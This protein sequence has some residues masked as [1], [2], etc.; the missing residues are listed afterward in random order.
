MLEVK[1]L[2]FSYRSYDGKEGRRLFDNISFSLP[3]KGTLL[4]LG[5]PGSGKSTLSLILS[6]LAP[7]FFDGH[8]EGDILLDGRS[9]PQAPEL[10]GVLSLV[11]QDS[12]QFII[13][14]Q[15]ED[16]IVYPLESLGV[17]KTKMDEKLAYE[18]EQWGLERLRHAGT[19][20][21]SGGEKR[22]LVLSASLVTEPEIVIYDE[23]FDDLDI[24]WRRKLADVIRSRRSASLVFAS[25]Y[26]PFFDGLFD[27][28]FVLKDG[29]LRAGC[30]DDFTSDIQFTHPD[31][32]TE[33]SNEL[34]AEGIVYTHHRHIRGEA[35]DFTLHADNFRLRSGEIVTLTGANG[36]GKS[37]FSRLLCGL[38]TPDEGMFS[39]NGKSADGSLLRRSAGYMFQ[40]PDFQIFLPTVRDELSFSLDYLKLSRKDKDNRL[41]ELAEL[42][43]LKLDETASLMSFG[44]RK[45]LQAAIYYNLDRP[46]FILDELDSALNYKEAFR[47]VSLLASRGAGIIL[48]THDADFASSVRTRGYGIEE[49]VLYEK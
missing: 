42:F 29:Q 2:S 14:S 27:Q 37:T 21:L 49:G 35:G 43:S 26:L 1:E 16:E 5:E 40:N 30:A 12:S 46:F 47:L 8:L 17:D 28:I 38:D 9:L 3:D 36:S 13:T 45:R 32:A 24:S 20:E 23:A 48:I 33:K 7:K 10:T 15:V 25:H 11:P 18:I 44:D 31:F 19:G 22:R 39:L 41:K 6:A 4:I 34:K